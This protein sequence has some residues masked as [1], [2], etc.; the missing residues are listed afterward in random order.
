MIIL[1]EFTHVL[2]FSS[3]FFTNYF[4]NILMKRDKFGIVRAYINSTKV[5]AVAKKYFNCDNLDGVELEEFGGEETLNSHWE[6]R[7]LLGEYM[8]GV[9]YNE[10]VVISEFTLALLEDSGYYKANYYT[11]GLMQYGKNKGCDFI[12]SKCVIDYKVN[13]KFQNEFFDFYSIKY[14]DD[15]MDPGCTSGRQSRV[16]HYL[17]YYKDGI[18]KSYQYY[19]DENIGG[20]YSADY[21]P[22]FMRDMISKNEDTYYTGHCSEIGNNQYGSYVTYKNKSI[23]NGNVTLFTGEE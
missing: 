15:I 18:T 4:N 19:N 20:K 8:N 10:E 14:D 5:V 22:I 6:A 7:I 17:L 2:G 1:H 13:P 12:Y 9:A 11:G 23:S 21:C 16:Y 3:H